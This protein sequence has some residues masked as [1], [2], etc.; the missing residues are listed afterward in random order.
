[1]SLRQKYLKLLSGLVPAG[2]LGAS[3]MLGAAVPGAASQDPA[4]AHPSAADEARVSERLAAIRE[5][6]SAIAG[7]Q[8][9]AA[10]PADLKLAWGNWWRNGGYGYGRPWAYRPWGNGGWNPWGNWRN[11]WNNWGNYWHNW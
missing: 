10:N 1:M 7:P 6:V 3:I 8:N 11:G 5:A 2:A 9:E 4:G